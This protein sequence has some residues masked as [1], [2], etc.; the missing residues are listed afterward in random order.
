MC[1]ADRRSVR[2][3]PKDARLGSRSRTLYPFFGGPRMGIKALVSTPLSSTATLLLINH[4]PIFSLAVSVS[5]LGL[6][7]S[8]TTPFYL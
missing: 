7:P 6:V 2:T 3:Q 4:V 1:S 5:R 8:Q